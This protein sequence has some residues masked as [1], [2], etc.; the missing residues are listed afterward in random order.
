MKLLVLQHVAC[1]GLG[2]FEK[3]LYREGI[4]CDYLPLFSRAKIPQDISSYAGMIVLG[5]PMNA[6]QEKEHPFLAKEDV[7]L[8]RAFKEDIPV[9]GICLGGQLMAKAAGAKV[10]AGHRKELG[11]YDITLSAEGMK[12]PL[13]AGFPRNFKVFQWHGDTFDIPAGAVKLASSAIFP[14]Q[15]FRLGR[16]YALQFHIEV[17]EE[18]ICEWIEE[19]EEEV[20]SLDYIDPEI[21][22]KDTKRYI[23]DL[24]GLADKFYGNFISTLR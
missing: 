1:E 6:Y 24:C 11:W 23:K 8:K 18:T 22:R 9:L 12:D 15:A 13:F 21:V 16:S 7:L 4:I 5:G 19:Y 17:S 2:G 10:A 14:N 20:E 3:A